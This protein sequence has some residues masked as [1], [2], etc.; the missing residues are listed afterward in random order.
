MWNAAYVTY[1]WLLNYGKKEVK[2]ENLEMFQRNKNRIKSR[3][4]FL[5][6]ISGKMVPINGV[7]DYNTNIWSNFSNIQLFNIFKKH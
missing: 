3:R 1:Y 7:P 2:P 4:T 6:Q 5:N